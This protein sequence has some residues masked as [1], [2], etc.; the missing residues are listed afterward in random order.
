MVSIRIIVIFS[1]IWSVPA[2]HGYVSSAYVKA[3]REEDYR[4][5]LQIPP[6][7]LIFYATSM[8]LVLT[9]SKILR[10]NWNAAFMDYGS[11]SGFG[12]SY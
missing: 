11:L 12:T 6:G 8:N 9:A 5:M 2:R 1:I 10:W 3:S 7:M 4:I